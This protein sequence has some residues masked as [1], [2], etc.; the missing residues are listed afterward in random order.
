MPKVVR[1]GDKCSGHGGYSSR[2]ST[3]ASPNVFVDGIPVVREGDSWASHCNSYTCHSGTS[4]TGSSTVFANGLPLSRVGD[5][6]S[7]GSTM[8]EGSPTTYS[9]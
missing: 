1:L 5:K 7:C 9:N 6:V 8:V 3:S 2:P 4:G